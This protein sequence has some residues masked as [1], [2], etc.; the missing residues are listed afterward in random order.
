[1]LPV[2]IHELGSVDD[3]ELTRVVCVSQF[4]DKWVY[5]KNKKRGGWEIP[6]GHIEKDE[7]WMDAA[8]R[9]LYE[10]TGAI[11]VEIIPICLYSITTYGILCYARIKK[12]GDLPESEIEKVGF[13]DEEPNDLTFKDTYN[14]FFKIVNEKINND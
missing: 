12:I 9:E 8:K 6:G 14:L 10:E 4:E 11:D 2:Y 5:S 1:M 3:K 13:F 7:T